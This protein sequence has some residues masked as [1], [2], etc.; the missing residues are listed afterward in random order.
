VHRWAGGGAA[1][2]AVRILRT[3]S[4]ARAGWSGELES[5]L[6]AHPERR[7]AG[8]TLIHRAL[9]CL[10][11]VHIRDACVPARS[12]AL[13]LESFIAEGGT[14]Y[15]VGEPNEDPRTHP[16]ATPLLTALVSSVVEHGR[17]MAERSPSGRLDP[18]LALILDDVAALAPLPG[19]PDLLAEGAALG[20]PALAVLRSPEQS[21]D[22]WPG[23]PWQRADTRL[24]LGPA[25]PSLF[26]QLPDAV[27]LD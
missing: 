27:C 21:R 11:S 19:L 1:L 23:S 8:Q 18:P 14:L 25:A 5:V 10:G 15:V 13:S 9:E 24:V 6:H 17:R 2:E 4:L 16:G 20:L 3:H 26:S 12:D 7:D 22:R